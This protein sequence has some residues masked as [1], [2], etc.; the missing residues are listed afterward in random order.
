MIIALNNVFNDA[1]EIE[2]R[3]YRISIYFY[4]KLQPKKYAILSRNLLP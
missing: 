2:N 3:C 4:V 1:L